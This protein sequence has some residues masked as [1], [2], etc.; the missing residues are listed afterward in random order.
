MDRAECKVLALQT[1]RD[2]G[3][4]PQWS[5]CIDTGPKLRLGHCRYSVSEI[6]LTDWYVDLN[7]KVTLMD[8]ILH[9]I[10]HALCP[11]ADHGP[12][13]QAKCLEIGCDPLRFKT[14]DRWPEAVLVAP[15]YN[16]IGTCPNCG[17]PFGVDKLPDPGTHVCDCRDGYDP[18]LC[19]IQYRPNPNAS[20]KRV[21]VE[22]ELIQNRPKK[23]SRVSRLASRLKTIQDM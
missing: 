1:M 14:F 8:T 6:G 15:T 22:A 17:R 3:L 21:A 13:W 16:Y 2:Y 19:T 10:A 4:L 5:F 7:T 18:E 20:S 23:S 9:E 11:G 12:I